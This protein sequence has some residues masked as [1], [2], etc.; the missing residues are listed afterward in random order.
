MEACAADSHPLG[1]SAMREDKAH[2]TGVGLNHWGDQFPDTHWTVLIQDKGKTPHMGSQEEQFTF[3]CSRYWYPLYAYLRK[4][5]HSSHDAQDLTQGFFTHLLSGDRISN[6][7]PSKGRFRSYLLGAMDH[8]LSD[9]RKYQNAQKRGGGKVPIS[10]EE[11]LAENRY[12]D[13]PTDDLTPAKLFERKWALTI[14][15]E[16]KGLLEQEFSEQGKGA[17]F[18][19]IEAFLIETPP[20]GAYAEIADKLKLKEDNVRAIV[21]RMRKRYKAILRDQVRATVSS[22]EEIDG[23]IRDLISSFG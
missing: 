22:A 20:P 14:L 23:E 9:R 1:F 16:S 18:S 4:R 13:E 5:G 2:Q 21:S 6:L 8:Y 12:Q 17:I 19:E 10:I 15:N 7:D 3:L 11:E